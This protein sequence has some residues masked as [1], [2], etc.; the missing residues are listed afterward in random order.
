MLVNRNGKKSILLL[1]F[2]SMAAC[3]HAQHYDIKLF[4]GRLNETKNRISNVK[5][6]YRR[7]QKEYRKFVVQRKERYHALTDSIGTDSLNYL[8]QKVPKDSVSQL[9]RLQE[10]YY[11]YFDSLYSLANLQ[12]WEQ[13]KLE[14]KSRS[15]ALVKNR[16]KGDE[17]MLRY[18]RLNRGISTYSRTLKIYKD[19]L[20]SID[21]L[22][23]DEIRFMLSQKKKELSQEYETK[24]ESI[25]KDLVSERMPD[26]PNGYQNRELL[27]FQQANNYLKSGMNNG[28]FSNLSREQSIDHFKGKPEVLEK[29]SEAVG[30]LKGKFSEVANSADLA[31]AKKRGALSG[32]PIG[33]RMI[34]GGS[35]QLH[36]DGE[37][38]ID[39]NPELGYRLN[40][41]LDVG[42][43]GTYRLMI[44]TD[45]FFQAIDNPKV[46]GGRGFVE[47]K[48]IKGFYFHG[49]YE[50]L[51]SSLQV[52]GEK[53]KGTWY[54]SVLVGIE[55]RFG[56]GGKLQGHA[57]LLYN[58]SSQSNPLY[59]SPWVFR[60][61]FN[62]SG[63]E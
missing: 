46:M 53:R 59:K 51:R 15:L 18:Q 24:F 14:A 42:L 58:L 19:S 25:T 9:L 8:L 44:S 50:S 11:V 28:G 48:L 57:L 63:S 17:Y 62:F 36:M 32:T 30:E 16:M 49:E 33:K 31:T 47:H 27:G 55:R 40:E 38:K 3:C 52:T 56:L 37:T 21:T 13:T 34:Y 10:D 29:A 1:L 22:D 43:G 45:D 60:F 20:S 61:G 12:G 54:N 35:F 23:R 26:L 2:L 41:K 4:D 7:I 5:R 39:L 6:E